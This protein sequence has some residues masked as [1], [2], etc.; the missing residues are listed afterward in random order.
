MIYSPREDS[1]LLEKQVKLYSKNKSVLDIGSGSGIQSLAALNSGAS[2]VTA[3]D[4]SDEVIS[5]L[6][7]IVKDNNYP[8]KII[9]SNLFSKIKSS[10]D[11]IVFN[12][13]YL[14][15]D[16][17]EDKDSQ[18]ATTG[19]KHGDE[20]ILNFLKQAQ[21]HLNK[22]GIILLLLSSLTPQDNITKLLS[23]LNLSYSII[24]SQ[25]LFFETLEVWEIRRFK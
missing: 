25:K 17:E 9:Q 21:A 22:K 16:K 18:L 3:S 11:L 7:K 23:Q 12:P 1:Y 14:P 10:F 19:G 15:E 20:I 13:P 24:S 6:K 8:I 2:S 4:I 5:H